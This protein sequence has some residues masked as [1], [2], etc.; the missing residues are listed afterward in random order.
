MV[1]IDLDAIIE[2][3]V[4]IKLFGKERELRYLTN[5]EDFKFKGLR[6]KIGELSQNP[7]SKFGE[8]E[9][10][11]KEIL[12]LL[13]KPITADEIGKLKQKQVETLLDEIDFIDLRNQGVIKDRESY[14]KLKSD[15]A[16]EN[17]RVNKEMGF[18]APTQ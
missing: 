3:K 6:Q 16:Q 10:T 13:I 1:D 8:V 15:V 12:E 5:R 4:K 9:K 7:S 17:M 14:N 18:L 11:Q 2:K